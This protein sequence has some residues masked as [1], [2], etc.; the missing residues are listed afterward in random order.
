MNPRN[1]FLLEFGM[2][3]NFDVFIWMNGII[4]SCFLYDLKQTKKIFRSIYIINL[5]VI[6]SLGYY[7]YIL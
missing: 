4:C 6:L 2:G 1:P 5:R 7:A 3:I